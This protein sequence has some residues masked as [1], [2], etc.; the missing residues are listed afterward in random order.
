MGTVPYILPSFDQ[1]MVI[2]IIILYLDF[3]SY[4]KKLRLIVVYCI[5]DVSNDNYVGLNIKEAIDIFTIRKSNC[6]GI[7]KGAIRGQSKS[8]S[9]KGTQNNDTAYFSDSNKKASKKSLDY[10]KAYVQN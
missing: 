9:K 10:S 1:A 5:I 7:Y 3:I 8:D 6:E 4:S 2:M